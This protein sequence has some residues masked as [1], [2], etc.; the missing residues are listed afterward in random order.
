MVDSSRC[1]TTGDVLRTARK[2]IAKLLGRLTSIGLAGI[3][4]QDGR[5]SDFNDVILTFSQRPS[6]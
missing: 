3:Q 2:F 1:I 5:N 4:R 6:V